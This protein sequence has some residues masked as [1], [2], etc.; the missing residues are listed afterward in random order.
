MNASL[1]SVSGASGTPRA[2][3]DLRGGGP[4]LCST[5]TDG[6]KPL[7]QTG[8]RPWLDLAV[9][10]LR[11]GARRLEV[12]EPG[13]GLLDHEQLLRLALVD[14]PALPPVADGRDAREPVGRT[15]YGNRTRSPAT[16]V[17][18]A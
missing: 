14:H 7:V 5:G 12:L 6:A 13:V 4:E 11:L 18:G 1:A 3:V 10:R 17:T 2:R 9:G 16:L 8:P 15:C